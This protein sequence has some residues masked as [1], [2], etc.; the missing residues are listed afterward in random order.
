MKSILADLNIE[1]G[2]NLIKKKLFASGT[3]EKNSHNED[4]SSTINSRYPPE[5]EGCDMSA[6]SVGIMRSQGKLSC[7]GQ[8]CHRRNTWNRSY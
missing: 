5:C 8:L 4:D 3:D 6:N 7:S 2:P 1:A